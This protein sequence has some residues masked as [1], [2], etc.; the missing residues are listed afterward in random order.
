MKSYQEIKEMYDCVTQIGHDAEHRLD[1]HFLLPGERL[2]YEGAYREAA[3]DA[4]V[5]QWVL[6]E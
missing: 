3:R 4:Q 2:K 6:G 1:E 5:L